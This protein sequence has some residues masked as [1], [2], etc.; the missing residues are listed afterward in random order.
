M[1]RGK[2][3]RAWA[4][5]PGEIL[6]RAAAHLRLDHAKHAEKPA[7]KV[8]CSAKSESAKRAWETMRNKKEVAA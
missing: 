1:M 3:R 6:E 7:L 8:V 2:A 4:S 5:E